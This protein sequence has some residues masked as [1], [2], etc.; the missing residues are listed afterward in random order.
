MFK[1]YVDWAESQGIR[2]HHTEKGHITAF[3]DSINENLPKSRKKPITSRQRRQYL[4]LIERAFD[5]MGRIGIP[6][7][8]PAR[9]E[10]QDLVK[11]F[12]Q[13]EDK[14]T[15]F[16]DAEERQK[17]IS[18]VEE[19]LS[20]LDRQ[21]DPL[22]RWHEYRD[23]ALIGTLFGV[24]MK[25]SLAASLTLNYIEAAI[26]P[27]DK[28]VKA[29]YMDLTPM[30]RKTYRPVVLPFALPLMKRWHEV[31][32]LLRHSR[33]HAQTLIKLPFKQLLAF[34]GGRNKGF[35]SIHSQKPTKNPRL[36]LVSIFRR[37]AELCA[38]AGISGRRISPQTL[39]NSYAA[40]LI[41]AGYTDDQLLP[42]LGLTSMRQVYR[43]R[44]AYLGADNPSTDPNPPTD[45][46]PFI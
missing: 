43:L 17:L 3:L 11:K 13:G 16:L 7:V 35:G 29:V 2:F 41:E 14:L 45:D 32:A 6:C 34:P 27:S 18:H 24:G 46:D 23:L 19:R 15:V 28:D 40:T 9:Q 26:D 1:R 33:P 39:R 44:T 4:L 8:N 10:G 37:S 25:V 20:F 21:G 5:Q 22:E 31:Y 36:S 42:C 30:A 38:Q 12:D